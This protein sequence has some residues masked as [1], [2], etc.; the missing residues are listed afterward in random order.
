MLRSLVL[1]GVVGFACSAAFCL[2]ATGEEIDESKVVHQLINGVEQARG[3]GVKFE[4]VDPS[5]VVM[6]RAWLLRTVDRL[7]EYITENPSDPKT[8]AWREGLRLADLR[9]ELS[10]AFPDALFLQQLL[11]EDTLYFEEQVG[12]KLHE[13][14]STEELFEANQAGFPIMASVLRAL[15][16]YQIVLE[17]SQFPERAQQRLDDR[18][19]TVQADLQNYLKTP[20]QAGRATVIVRLHKLLIELDE[21]LQVRSLVS[22]IREHYLRPRIRVFISDRVLTRV[23]Q[24]MPLESQAISQQRRGTLVSGV[25]VPQGQLFITGAD[26]DSIG[27]LDAR[28]DAPV[29]F[30]GSA[31][32]KHI[33]LGISANLSASLAKRLF[34]I[35]GAADSARTASDV[36]LV[37]TDSSGG[38]LADAL[39]ARAASRSFNSNQ[40]SAML[41]Q[42]VDSRVTGA[43][44]YINLGVVQ[45]LSKKLKKL[46]ANTTRVRSYRSRRNGIELTIS[47]SRNGFKEPDTVDPPNSF[48]DHS[49]HID[50]AVSLRRGLSQQLVDV[51]LPSEQQPADLTS[52]TEVLSNAL[53]FLRGETSA[54][55]SDKLRIWFPA[56]KEIVSYTQ[57]GIQ[58]NFQ[59][60]TTEKPQD[61]HPATVTLTYESVDGAL[62]FGY[63]VSIDG[64]REL[65]QKLQRLLG[66]FTKLTNLRLPKLPIGGLQSLEVGEVTD[67]ELSVNKQFVTISGVLASE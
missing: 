55:A 41:N 62:K 24:L 3:M 40:I 15:R 34:V 2:E 57:N 53:R 59:V 21:S 64:H 56:D 32:R 9:S 22:N 28:Y 29:A 5:T 16:R 44:N 10:K 61:S 50:F 1:S 17:D 58:A 63:D 13:Y 60:A 19:K 65:E 43:A 6:R 31:R 51:Y 54:A 45:T 49:R 36:Q 30:T 46:G 4:P 14:D 23:V 25:A 37:S 67:L 47:S 27:I 7:E 35:E 52:A 48:D 18:L 33:S 20:E 66:R 26:S 39:V 42:D 12:W 11:N 38:C 8:H